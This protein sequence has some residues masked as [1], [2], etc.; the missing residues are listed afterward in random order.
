MRALAVVPED[1]KVELLDVARPGRDRNWVQTVPGKSW[2]TIFRLYG[3]LQPWFDKTW[4]LP[5]IE[6]E[7]SH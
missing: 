7:S 6:K 3:P 5:D 4:R 1:R 2:F